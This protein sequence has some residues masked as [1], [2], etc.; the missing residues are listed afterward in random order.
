MNDLVRQLFVNDEVGEVVL[1]RSLDIGLADEKSQ[2]QFL[3]AAIGYWED[4]RALFCRDT[5]S[6]WS[7]MSISIGDFSISESKRE[8]LYK[9]PSKCELCVLCQELLD[10]IF[11]DHR[12]FNTLPFVTYLGDREYSVSFSLLEFFANYGREATEIYIQKVGEVINKRLA[13][14]LTIRELQLHQER[15]AQ[16][17]GRFKDREIDS[18]LMTQLSRN[19]VDQSLIIVNPRIAAMID[20]RIEV[21]QDKSCI[22]WDQVVVFC[23]SQRQ[24]QEWLWDDDSQASKKDVT[25]CVEGLG[26]I[27]IGEQEGVTTVQVEIINRY[28][29]RTATFRFDQSMA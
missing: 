21:G 14:S 5:R 7:S 13:L 8:L 15:R 12:K 2:V 19:D 11:G 26:L 10:R 9:T 18:E 24:L 25:L 17:L 4:K 28:G 29:N 22:Y 1:N 27:E 6:G 23:G 20:G 3:L 16:I